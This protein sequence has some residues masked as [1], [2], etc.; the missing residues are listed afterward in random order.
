MR[1]VHHPDWQTWAEALRQW[2]IHLAVPDPS[3]DIWKTEEDA[4]NWLISRITEFVESGKG[5]FVWR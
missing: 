4:A 3:G 2:F 5:G 1:V